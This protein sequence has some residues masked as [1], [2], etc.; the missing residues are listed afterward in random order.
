MQRFSFL[1][2]LIKRVDSKGDLK[3]NGATNKTSIP[4][5]YMESEQSDVCEFVTLKQSSVRVLENGGGNASNKVGHPLLQI[6]VR[7][8]LQN[9]FLEDDTERLRV[10]TVDTRVSSMSMCTTDN[11]LK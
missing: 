1:T 4:W 9:R 6:L 10:C 2:H 5:W 3:T 11:K 8:S 7:L